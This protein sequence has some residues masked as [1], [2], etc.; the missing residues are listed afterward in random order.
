MEEITAKG[1][2]AK[3]RGFEKGFI[4]TH[5]IQL[6]NKLGILEAFN[7][8]KSGWTVSGLSAKID[9]HPPYLKIWCQTAFHLEILNC[10]SEGRF[11]FQPFL[12]EILGD[13]GSVK[14]YLANLSIDV[15]LVGKGM[16]EAAPYFRTGAVMPPYGES[17]ISRSVYDTTKNIYLAFLFMILPKHDWLKQSLE[18]GVDF[19]DVGCGDGSLIIQLAQAFPQSKFTGFNPDEY[20]IA[21]ARETITQL[22]MEDRVTVHPLGGQDLSDNN[23]YDLISLVV[24][25]HEILPEIRNNAMEK[26]YQALKP[27]GT[28]LMLDFPFPLHIL[29]F[30]N[31]AY[32]Y[33][34][35]DQ[36]YEMCCGVVHL[37]SQ[38]QNDLLSQVGF[39]NIN[40]MPIGKG[41]FDFITAGK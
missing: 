37:S 39:K 11:T 27:G 32:D 36:F 29:D 8:N 31:P 40:R 13:K 22:G 4:A 19:L 34:I 18:N 41:M 21:F 5:L 25:L 12:D 23:H 24:T 38:E 7:Q 10:D 9:I 2:M 30:R 3:V 20:G 17:D 28:L 15:E 6:G 26:I 16:V 14:N 1:Q 33:G 35:L